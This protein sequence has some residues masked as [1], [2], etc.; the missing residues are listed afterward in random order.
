MSRKYCFLKDLSGINGILID[1]YLEIKTKKVL[2]RGCRVNFIIYIRSLK[3]T[4]CKCSGEPKEE[5]ISFK[6]GL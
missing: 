4:L 3:F 6:K 2:T 1:M 5:I